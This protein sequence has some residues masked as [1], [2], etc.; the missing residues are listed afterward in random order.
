MRLFGHDYGSGATALTILSLGML[1]L[2]G[3]GSNGI[4]LLMAGRSSWSLAI[5]ATSLAVNLTL[6]LLLI[7]HLGIDGAAVAWAVTVLVNNGVTAVL[8]WKFIR[9]DPLGNGALVA[10]A[11]SAIFAVVGFGARLLFG[12]TVPS[13]LL[14]LAVALL[15]V[16]RRSSGV[17]DGS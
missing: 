16:L 1:V 10:L 2:T 4:A 6:N 7:P 9:L 17:R 8:V 12:P 5:S 3:T 15:A 13:F 11:V 14:A